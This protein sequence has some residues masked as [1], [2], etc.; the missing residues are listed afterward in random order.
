MVFPVRS[1]DALGWLS[2][3]GIV[4]ALAAAMAPVLAR[5]A[6]PRLPRRLADVARSFPSVQRSGSL[7]WAMLL[8]VC[9]HALGAVTG[10]V[11]LVSIDPTVPLTTSLTLVPLAMV[12][13]FFPFTISGLGVRE[14]AFVLLFEQV[15]V[16]GEDAIA[17]SLALL[18]THLTAA[19][20]GGLVHL[21][22][23]LHIDA[24]AVGV[25]RR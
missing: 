15:G 19:S 13:A 25:D 18:A 20:L 16:A 21:I 8:S 9:T 23:P 10:H 11:L 22:W 14:A 6:A 2:G 7:V 17:C 5:R 4:A 12:A 24:P 3:A 1:T